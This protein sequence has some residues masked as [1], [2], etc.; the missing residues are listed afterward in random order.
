MLGS[1]DKMPV[2]A[3]RHFRSANQKH[4]AKN[5]IKNP[6]KACREHLALRR[7]CVQQPIAK[8]FDLKNTR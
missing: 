5:P 8:K 4:P 3:S 6:V 7:L 1:N 2:P